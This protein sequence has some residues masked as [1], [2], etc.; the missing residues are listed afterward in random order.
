MTEKT[1]RAALSLGKETRNYLLTGRL[2]VPTRKVDT[3]MR[4]IMRSIASARISRK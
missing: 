4:S 2:Q 1:T 3:I